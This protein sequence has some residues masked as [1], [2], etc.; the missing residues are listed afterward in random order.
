MWKSLVKIWAEKFLGD[1]LQNIHLVT[2]SSSFTGRYWS[3]VKILLQYKKGS[4]ISNTW[5]KKWGDERGVREFFNFWFY[6]VNLA[7]FWRQ[8]G[9]VALVIKDKT[10]FTF[11][12]LLFVSC[13]F[14][15]L[16]SLHNYSL[17]SLNPSMSYWY[18]F[19]VHTYTTLLEFLFIAKSWQMV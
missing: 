19:R 5:L 4:K 6:F 18:L 2:S 12:S 13:Y 8:H 1:H 17:C 11:C 16:I 9:P 15:Y 10:L 7:L 3:N 14:T